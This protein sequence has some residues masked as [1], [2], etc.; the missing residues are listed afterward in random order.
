VYG[1][2]AFKPAGWAKHTFSLLIPDVELPDSANPSTSISTVGITAV[3]RSFLAGP[4]H[5]QRQTY[6]SHV[7]HGTAGVAELPQ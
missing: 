5:A 6:S 1:V 3:H 7:L 2:R 4:G